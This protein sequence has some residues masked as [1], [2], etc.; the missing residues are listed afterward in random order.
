MSKAE[1]LLNTLSEDNVMALTAESSTEPH[2]VI[3]SDR[4][5]AV[6]SQ[7]KRIA[8]QYDHNIE[9]VTFDCPRYWDDHDMS[10]MTIY[11][12]YKRP[13]SKL[14]SYI[15]DNITIDESDDTIMHFDWTISKNVTE[16]AGTIS[17]LVCIKTVNDEGEDV[18]HWNS[19][20]NSEMYVSQGLEAEQYFEE[21]YPDIITQLLLR[22]DSV[23]SVKADADAGKF[24]GVSVTHEWNGTVLTLTSAS[25][26]TSVDLKGD[27]GDKGDQGDK[28]DKGEAFVYSDFT[29]EQLEGLR[30]PQGVQGETGPKGEKGDTGDRGPQGEVGPQG[31]QGDKGEAFVYSDFT[32][33]Q[34]EGLRGPQGVQ[35]EKGLKGDT[36]ATGPKGD[37]GETGPQGEKGDTGPQGPKGDTGERG[38]QGYPGVQGERGPKGDTG[39]Q[40]PQGETGPQGEKGDKG[41]AF[42]YADFTTE[43][44][45]GL[46]GA[47]G[48]QGETGPQGEKGDKGDKGDTGAT[49]PQGPQGVQGE[50]GPKGDKGDK[51]DIGETGPQGPK[52]DKGDKG[53]TGEQGPKGDT[54]SGF[55]VLGYFAT[56]DALSSAVPTPNV[57][58]AYG[59]GSSDPYDIY[60]YDA[61]K[62]WVNNGP[63]QGAKGEKG[64][65]GDP[66]TYS[67]FT[68]EQLAGLKGEKGDTGAQGPQGETGPQ[69][70][71]GAKGE[72]GESGV[73]YG[74]DTP[75][76]EFDV[77][78]NPDGTPGGS[79]TNVTAENIESALGYKPVREED[80]NQLKSDVANVQLAVSEK[81]DSY[82]IKTVMDSVATPHTQYYLGNQTAVNIVLP[83]SADVGQIITVCWYNGDT[84]AT[85]SV[86]GTMLAF[87]YTPSANTRSE[88]NALWDG[89]YWAVLG[90]E[91]A[92]PKEVK[93]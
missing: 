84:A 66:F 79:D 16:K 2:I 6:P 60:I 90:N 56:V 11:I 89:T 80:V 29:P 77:W 50:Q 87:D 72:K 10:T 78:I 59:V 5:I 8:V 86:T 30:G 17:F 37:T 62:G 47:Q 63:L 41:D 38:P 26:T 52:G 32:Q 46:R 23:E 83:D 9:T 69:G 81:M 35:G 43:Q 64:D 42:T 24:N 28:G 61:V 19:E 55:K 65:K 27:K 49:G 36:G 39:P 88:I 85:L 74:T 20:L 25:G 92:V 68:A 14:G 53:D 22:M 15:A 48:P 71:V 51:G 82:T 40:G 45:E 21:M 33:E 54:G 67:D 93:V 44:L 91:M 57:G 73:Y 70:P 3:G 18:N 12:N 58:D 7:L 4:H 13:D 76:E 34:L 75:G 31:P 1:E